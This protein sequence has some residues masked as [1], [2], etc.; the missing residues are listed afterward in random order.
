MILDLINQ[1]I[2]GDTIKQLSGQIGADEKSTENAFSAA[3]PLLMGALTKNSGQQGGAESLFSA[4]ERD[5]DGSVLENISGLL[6]NPDSANGAGILKHLLGS[7]QG[8]VE[9]TLS[10]TSGLDAA[11][12]GKLL[13]IAAPLIMGALGQARKK[14]NL[15]PSGLYRMLNGEMKTVEKRGVPTQG[16][17][18]LLDSDNDGDITDDLARMGT[19]ILGKLF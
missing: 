11:S 16:I 14:E 9:S 5:H 1:S 6:S 2:G 10:Q 7:R 15:D 13:Q 17:M 12:I 8:R 18:S 19:S 3:I 4:L